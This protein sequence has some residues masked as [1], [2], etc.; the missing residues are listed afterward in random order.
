MLITGNKTLY[1]KS[2]YLHAKFMLFYMPDGRK[3]ALTGS[4]NLSNAGVMLG[5]REI[6]L[7]TES[8][9]VVRQLEAFVKD[10]AD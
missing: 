8:P 3:I 1:K 4:H 10:I 7:Q 5:T 9:E 2:R 6:A